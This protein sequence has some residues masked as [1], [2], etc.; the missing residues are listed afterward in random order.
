V[1]AQLLLP[2]LLAPADFTAVRGSVDYVTCTQLHAKWQLR[3]RC[4]LLIGSGI[5][6]L[7]RAPAGLVSAVQYCKRT[8][9]ADPLANYSRTCR[10]C[11][12]VSLHVSSVRYMP[13]SLL[14]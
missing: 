6:T 12:V 14:W 3:Q 1:G 7:L 10:D 11:R 9:A 2:L 8:A 4:T 13:R 5:C